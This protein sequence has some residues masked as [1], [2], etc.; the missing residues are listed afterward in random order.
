M[1]DDLSFAD[2]AEHLDMKESTLRR[3]CLEGKGPT[4]RKQARTF[5][6]LPA[7]L[8]KWKADFLANAYSE[9]VAQPVKGKAKPVK[10]VPVKELA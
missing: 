9:P 3:L 1:F 8:D 6:F 4:G 7:T 10:K 2:A 5:R